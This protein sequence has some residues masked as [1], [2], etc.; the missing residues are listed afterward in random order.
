MKFK[1]FLLSFVAAGLGAFEARAQKS[2]WQLDRSPVGLT[3]TPESEKRAVVQIY[4]ARAYSWRGYFGVH[5]WV[6]VKEENASEYTVYEVMGFRVESG[7]PVIRKTHRQP[8]S[9]WMGNDPTMLFDLRG[10]KAAKMIPEIEKAVQSYPY[11]EFYR[12]WPG[13]NSNTFVSHIMR[14]TPGIYVELPPHAIGKDWIGEA[15]PVGWTESGTGVQVSLFGALGFSLGLAEGVELN[16]LGM[17]FGV[18]VLRPALKLPFVGRVGFAD[19][20]LFGGEESSPSPV[21]DQAPGADKV[22]PLEIRR[23]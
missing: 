5:S 16:L 2:W 6:A 15:R 20:A 1:L 21:L 17:T 19:K 9:R 18:D 12:L 8:D 7:V 13:P 10:E 23:K 14:N 4:A 11:P 22:R 3:P